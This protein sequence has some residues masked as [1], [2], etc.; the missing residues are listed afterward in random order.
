[1]KASRKILLIFGFT[2]IVISS[3]AQEITTYKNIETNHNLSSSHSLIGY[4]EA[5]ELNKYFS[6][7]N[8]STKVIELEPIKKYSSAPIQM[9]YTLTDGNLHLSNRTFIYLESDRYSNLGLSSYIST[10]VALGWRVNDRMD[11]T[12]G[13]LA[14]KEFSVARGY[15]TN[16]S[17]VKFNLRYRV[18]E[19]ASINIWRQYISKDD[20]NTAKYYNM[21]TPKTN[22]GVSVTIKISENSQIGVSTQYQEVNLL[23]SGNYE[24]KGKFQLKF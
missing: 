4:E 2:L 18:N 23:N 10:H 19:D 1:M 6:I 20:L 24:S 12:G 8:N 16:R 7:I 13:V 15:T 11:I 9:P 22:S 14:I 5:I 3:L 21:V 17:G